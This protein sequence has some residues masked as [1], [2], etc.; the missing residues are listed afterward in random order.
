MATAVHE[1]VDRHP[2]ARRPRVPGWATL[3]VLLAVVVV[4][5]L[6][7]LPAS[8]LVVIAPLP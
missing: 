4:A 3:G 1:T 8:F 5:P 7:A 2:A 6:L